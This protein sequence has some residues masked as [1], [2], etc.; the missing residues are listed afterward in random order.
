MLPKIDVPIFS[1]TLISSGKKV[2]FRPFTVKEEKIFLMANE[3]DDV[4]NVVDSIKQ[5]LNNCIIDE[6]DVESLP[7]FDIENLFL[8]LR[9]RSVGEVANLRYKCNNII[10]ATDEKEE[11]ACNHV[12]EYDLKLLDI[13]P[14]FDEQHNKKIELTDSLGVVMK[15]PTF[16]LLKEFDA[17]NEIDSI[18]NMTVQCIDYIYSKEELFYAKDSTKQELVDFIEGMQSGDIEKIK[19][20]FDTMPKIKTVIDFK[21]GKCNYEEKIDVEGIQN[22]FG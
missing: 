13:K 4:E 9:A 10:P 15:Y 21:C 5:V 8:Q 18:I 11:H 6:I 16:D 7:L 2:K 1:T 20:F 22:F 3:S 17:S 12:V 14:S 19:L